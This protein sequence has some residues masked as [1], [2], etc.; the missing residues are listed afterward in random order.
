MMKEK[1]SLKDALF[2]PSKVTLLATQ[3][4]QVFHRFQ[5]ETF[6]Q[7]VIS[8][9]P[10]LEL[11]Q[12]ITHIACCLHIYLPSDYP[13][14]LAI[15]LQALPPILDPER[16]DDDFWDFI[17]AS[18]GEFVAMYGCTD[19]YV[20]HS[21]QALEQITMRF[22][23]EYAIRSFAVVYPEQTYIQMQQWAQHENYHVRR[24]TSEW[25][26]PSLPRGKNIWWPIDMS[27][28]ILEYIYA[29]S[30]MF[31]V[32]S[33]ANHLNDLSKHHPDHVIAT[34]QRWKS[35]WRQE[36][37][38]MEFLIRHALRTQIK[39]GYRA[40]LS[41]VGK[42]QPQLSSY[43]CDI[44]TP[45]VTVGT[46][47][48]F[49]FAATSLQDQNL[50]LT[51]TIYFASAT[52][53]PRSKIFVLCDKHFSSGD[54]IYIRKKHLMKD[55]STRKLYAGL[56]RVEVSCGGVMLGADEFEVR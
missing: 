31:V 1:F 21:F 30:T 16:E 32:R 23:M 41:L 42:Q 6:I 20:P 38:R 7:S 12:R 2:N 35:L 48:E 44:E 34:L 54:R 15:I 4:Q 27:L 19:E 9:F 46:Y 11:K 22:S 28:S 5:K 25:S 8:Q 56:H 3:I 45:T 52:G 17:Y 33:V 49:S 37:K 55:F 51:Y 13:K 50:H 43:I 24:L 26:R 47:L 39:A 53:R 29:D 18:Y 14:A 36:S 40:A 10:Q